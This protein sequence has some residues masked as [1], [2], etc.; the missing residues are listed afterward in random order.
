MICFDDH[1]MCPLL[2]T[3]RDFKVNRICQCLCDS[4]LPHVEPSSYTCSEVNIVAFPNFEAV[5]RDI[6]G[7]FKIT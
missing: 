6:L 4:G 3:V 7:D 2:L 5:S 1:E